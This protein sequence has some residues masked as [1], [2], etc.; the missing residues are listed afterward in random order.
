MERPALQ[1]RS[2]DCRPVAC[3]PSSKGPVCRCARPQQ[4][5]RCASSQPAAS[6]QLNVSVHVAAVPLTG[7]FEV[8]ERFLGRLYPDQLALHTLVILED[9]GGCTAY[10]FLPLHPTS[11]LTT[12]RWVCQLAACCIKSGSSMHNPLRPVL[13]K[14]RISHPCPWRGCNRCDLLLMFSLLSTELLVCRL[15]TGQAVPGEARVRHL[16]SGV[17]RRRCWKVAD[18]PP[19]ARLALRSFDLLVCP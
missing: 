8:A 9:P 17:P 19:Q 4:L 12:S 1:W 13:R 5:L 7:A 16:R 3:R 6:Q 15:M 10:D 11:P 18:A 14:G 2:H